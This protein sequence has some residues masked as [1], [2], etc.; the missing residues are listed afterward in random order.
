MRGTIHLT[1]PLATWLGWSE[2]PGEAAGYG[3]LDADDSRS[4]AAMLA[5]HPAT[6][7]CVTLT[8]R[9]GRPV[10]HGCAGPRPGPAP[11]RAG[12]GRA[13][14]PPV[15]DWLRRVRITPL[16]TAPCT[17]PREGRGYRPGPTLRHLI[18]VR[19]PTCAAPG[20]RRPAQRCDLDH[21]TPH[22]LGGRTCEC[23]LGPSCKR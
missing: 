14:S 18:Q 3:P 19:N 4:V 22:H 5:A 6:T 17:H 21:T 2:A 23:N 13:P 12:P 15:P 20:C 9:A 10:A 7:W 8:G 1:L 11:P 16:Q